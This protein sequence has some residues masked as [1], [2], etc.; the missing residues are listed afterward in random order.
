MPHKPGE[1]GILLELTS[2]FAVSSILSLRPGLKALILLLG[3]RGQQIDSPKARG[4]LRIYEPVLSSLL[5]TVLIHVSGKPAYRAE[6]LIPV[7]SLLCW[8]PITLALWPL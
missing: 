6:H 4:I 3:A 1:N 8:F 2:S 5:C 7:L